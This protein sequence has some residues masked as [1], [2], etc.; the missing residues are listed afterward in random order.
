MTHH[1]SARQP[2]I[3]SFGT[4]R[5][6]KQMRALR[7]RQPALDD[8]INAIRGGNDR[9]LHALVVR[10]QHGDQDS[11]VTAISALLPRLAAVVIRRLPIREWQS[12]IDEYITFAYLTI[13]DVNCDNP[14]AY[15]ADKIISRTRRRY[16]RAIESEAAIPRQRSVLEALGPVDCDLERRVLA[17]DELTELVRAVRAGLLD[18]SSWHNLLRLRFDRPPGAV[19]TARERT[20]LTRAQ[21]RINDWRSEAA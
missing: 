18:E 1:H 8:T 13:R 9:V 7:K 16:E 20:S 17:R 12:G 5:L 4:R 2:T 11:A 3:H 10:A 21:R 19:A 14:P 15:L 6:A